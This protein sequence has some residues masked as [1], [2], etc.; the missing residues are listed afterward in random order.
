MGNTKHHIALLGQSA[1]CSSTLETHTRDSSV[2]V[3]SYS[4]MMTHI[5]RCIISNPITGEKKGHK[6]ENILCG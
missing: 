5:D 1:I 3:L 2:R 6:K 4:I